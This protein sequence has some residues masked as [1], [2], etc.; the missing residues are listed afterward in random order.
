MT[1]IEA[2]IQHNQDFVSRAFDANSATISG[3]MAV[4]VACADPRVD[5]IHVI[6]LKPE[7]TIV[8]RNLGGRINPAFWQTMNML[9]T[10]A[11]V[12]GAN[13]GGGSRLDLIVLHHTDCGVTRLAGRR[14]ML[15]GFFGVDQA[16]VDAKAV[17]DPR[18]AVKLE[19]AAL[20][21]SPLPPSWVVSGLAY[22]V[23]TGL[24]EVAVTSDPAHQ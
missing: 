15:S 8:L 7:E 20:R 24:V 13:P 18:A 19:V 2:I 12:D 23:K 14:D 9:Q 1:P 17:S 5:P 21:A 10:V 3:L 6:G 16:E 22:D 4:V 11:Q